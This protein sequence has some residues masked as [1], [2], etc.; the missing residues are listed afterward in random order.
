MIRALLAIS[1]IRVILFVALGTHI[2]AF[3]IGRWFGRGSRAIHVH[4]NAHGSHG[5]HGSRSRD[6]RGYRVPT[7]DER[8]GAVLRVVLV[9]AIAYIVVESGLV[10]LSP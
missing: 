3:A 4:C 1:A 8:I 7:F 6:S 10:S 2:I 5:S 9:L